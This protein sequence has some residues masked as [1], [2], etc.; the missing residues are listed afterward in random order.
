[1]KVVLMTVCVVMVAA[2]ALCESPGDFEK[3]RQIEVQGKPGDFSIP[4][5][6][7][8]VD[9]YSG[10]LT[11]ASPLWDRV[12]LCDVSPACAASCDDSSQNG[13]YYEVIPIG[14]TAVENLECAVTA[15][16]MSDTTMYVYCDPFEPANP[17]A[18]VVAWD[19]DDG[20]GNWSAFTAA[21]GVTLQPGQTYYLVLSTFTPGITGTFTIDFTSATV[22]VVPVELQAF[23]V[24]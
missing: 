15:S 22:H 20:T 8:L 21:D 1:M 10:E 11:S 23:S 6:K 4:D 13:E 16:T 19:D 18:N 24:E 14:V 12:Y 17:F 5:G 9:T 3:Q 2:F 7:L